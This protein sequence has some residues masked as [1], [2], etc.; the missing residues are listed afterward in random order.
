MIMCVG[1]MWC[2][3]QML[4]C[5][6]FVSIIGGQSHN[7]TL[8]PNNQALLEPGENIQQVVASKFPSVFSIY[9]HT[10]VHTSSSDLLG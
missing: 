5:V 6:I 9:L 10:Y 1:G 8:Y 2:F 7:V 3:V 4:H